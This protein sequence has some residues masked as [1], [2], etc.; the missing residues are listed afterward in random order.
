VRSRSAPSASMN[1]CTDSLWVPFVCRL[2]CAD[3]RQ[4]NLARGEPRRA[5]GGVTML[6]C[7]GRSGETAIELLL[8][9]AECNRLLMTPGGVQR[10][11][12]GT[13]RL[14]S[15]ARWCVAARWWCV[16]ARWRSRERVAAQWRRA[17]MSSDSVSARGGYD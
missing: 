8:C 3:G 12:G 7:A 6:T 15:G 5:A 9:C 2:A 17:V 10:L 4:R 14:G 16:A 1:P 11:G 13:R